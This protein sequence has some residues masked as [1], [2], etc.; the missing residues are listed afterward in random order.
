[1]EVSGLQDDGILCGNELF[2][3]YDSTAVFSWSTGDS[4]PT[5]MVSNPGTYSVIIA[6]PRGCVL[7]DTISITGFDT[8]PTVDLGDDVVA[9]D[10]TVL[11]AGN[12]G[13]SY[14]WS[15]GETTQAIT[16]TSSGNYIVQVSNANNCTTPDTVGVLI[17]PSPSASFLFNTFNQTISFI[18]SSTFG[19]YVWQFGDGN[20]SS[21]I[22]PT[23][24]YA[25]GGTYQ[26]L[27]IATNDCGSDTFTQEVVV[28]N[29][30]LSPIT[31]LQSLKAYPNP[32]QSAILIEW[33]LSSPLEVK[34]ALYNSV[35]QLIWQEEHQAQQVKL[36]RSLSYLPPGIYHL[37]L[38]TENGRKSL[39]IIK[40]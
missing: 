19:T 12:P 24:T 4:T 21:Q 2:T 9:C 8:F 32:T 39:P 23:H 27:L 11:N 7:F 16:A 37:H 6:E 1:P 28:L 17:N 40:Q 35:G 18:N 3:V 20:S 25:S 22:S 26:V 14:L 15:N 33:E 10:S 29:T 36:E 5:I 31:E 38:F 30:G 34:L 13:L